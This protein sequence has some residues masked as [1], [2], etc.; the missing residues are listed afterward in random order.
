M[1]SFNSWYIKRVKSE[2][3]IP[4]LLRFDSLQVG[5]LA[6][7]NAT[8]AKTLFQEMQEGGLPGAICALISNTYLAPMLNWEVGSIPRFVINQA[9]SQH[10]GVEMYEKLKE[11]GVNIVV[12]C[13]FMVDVPEEVHKQILTLIYTLLIQNGLE[14]KVCI[15]R[16][17]TKRF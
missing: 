3:F 13:G 17:Y 12:C 1:S 16:V 8:A 9:T 6:S 5:V 10:P 2:I 11:N 7:G 15:K 4:E 14:A